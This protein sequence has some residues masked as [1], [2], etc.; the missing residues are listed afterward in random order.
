MKNFYLNVLKAGRIFLLFMVL[1]GSI[2]SEAYGIQQNKK[3]S[4]NNE[5]IS[6][7]YL[8][9]P[10]SDHVLS[11]PARAPSSQY[12]ELAIRSNGEF[13][14]GTLEGDPDNPN[15]NNKKLLYGHPNPWSSATTIRID[16]SDYWNYKGGTIGTITTAPYDSGNSN[17][18]VWDINGIRVTQT[19]TIFTGSTT[20]R[21]DNVEIK[22]TI[23]N[24]TSSSHNIGVR[25]MLDT[26]LGSNDGAPFRI[27]GVGDVTTEMEFAS[28]NMPQYWQ[29]FDSLSNPTVQSQGTLVGGNATVPDRFVA[30]YWRAINDTPWD[31]SI[32]PSRQITGDSAVGTYWNPVVL[33][34]GAS[35]TFI[36]YYGL[37]GITGGGNATFTVG[38]SSYTALTRDEDDNLT[39]NPFTVTAYVENITSFTASSVTATISLPTGLELNA[40]EEASKN[41]GNINANSQKQISWQ[42]Q[43]T[44][45]V[46][47]NLTYS[48]T[49]NDVDPADPITVDR[50]IEIP[51]PT[52]PNSPTATITSP[53]DGDE[54]I[55]GTLIAF[56][57]TGNDPED[58]NLTGSSLVW[59]SNI[60]GQIGTGGTISNYD[61]SRLSVGLHIITLTATD[62]GGKT[63]SASIQ[64]RI[65]A[66]NLN[67][68]TATINSP[69]NGSVYVIG[70][71]IS[72]SGSATDPEDGALGGGSL[73]WTSNKDGQIGTDTSFNTTT[74]SVG[75]HIITLTATDSGGLQGMDQISLIISFIGNINVKDGDGN[76]LQEAEVKII[77]GDNE[78]S[79]G[80]TDEDGN[81]SNIE[82]RI[83]DKVF[84]TKKVHEEDQTKGN[85]PDEKKYVVRLDNA[86]IFEDTDNDNLFD[87]NNTQGYIISNAGNQNL[88]LQHTKI[89]YNLVV[90]IEWD[91]DSSYLE[92]VKTG[93]EKA[94]ERLYDATDG[95]VYF[96]KVVVYDNKEEWGNA[97]IQVFAD[98]EKWYSANVNGINRGNGHI[99]FERN[100]PSSIW[101][102]GLPRWIT[103]TGKGGFATI[104][105]EFGHYGFGLGDQYCYYRDN[106]QIAIEDYIPTLMQRENVETEFAN[107]QTHL[108]NVTDINGNPAQTDQEERNHESDWKTIEDLHQRD[109][110]NVYVPIIKPYPTDSAVDE[111]DNGS[112]PDRKSIWNG[113]LGSFFGGSDPIPLCSVLF[114]ADAEIKNTIDFNLITSQADA[115]VTLFKSDP[116][117]DWIPGDWLNPKIYQGKTNLSR[118]IEVLGAR[119]DND[120]VVIQK[121]N[122]KTEFRPLSQSSSQ[123]APALLA[124]RAPFPLSESENEVFIP[125]SSAEGLPEFIVEAGVTG[126]ALLVTIR[127][128]KGLSSPPQAVHINEAGTLTNLSL[129]E[130]NNNTFTGSITLPE[131]LDAK[132]SLFI[133]G[134]DTEDNEVLWLSEIDVCQ[135][136]P[137]NRTIWSNGE[138][139]IMTPPGEV[140]DTTSL[141]ITKTPVPES[142]Q[143]PY[144]AIA[145]S[146][147]NFSLPDQGS[148]NGALTFRYSEE[149]LA[150]AT[151]NDLKVYYWDSNTEKWIEVGGVVDTERNTVS[152]PISHFA[153]YGLFVT[154][155]TSPKSS[156]ATPDSAIFDVLPITIEG[157][158]S[159]SGGSGVASVE[160]SLDGGNTW[161]PTSPSPSGW[162]YSFTPSL[163]GTYHLRSRAKDNVGN[164]EASTPEITI[165]YSVGSISVSPT[166][167]N[168]GNVTVGSSSAPQTFT[169]SNIGTADLVLGT[170]TH[171]GTN[172]SEFSIPNDQ[173][174]GQTIPPAEN[175]TVQVVF[176]PTSAGSKIAN[177]S[178]P[179]NA[180]TSALEVTLLGIGI[181]EPPT[182]NAGLDRTVSVNSPITLDGSNSSD[183]DG[184]PLT[185]QWTQT[186]G[187]TVSLSSS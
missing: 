159:D 181:G 155:T 10:I 186:A 32:D 47:G 96:N 135:I 144:L 157:T 1:I 140:E 36:T 60:D 164:Q 162:T 8:R 64:I 112:V 46:H 33:Q 114:D 150:G 68:P 111:V 27:P 17:I 134:N 173:C 125:L 85:H 59:T 14:M 5:N 92:D 105:H 72:F 172:A 28:S 178:I 171:T 93:F 63:G 126:Q 51:P 50:S 148:I 165:S 26:M 169:I 80:Q 11:A 67:A 95:Q 84:A 35:K 146:G 91:V 97:D 161:E 152:A 118:A 23:V 74:L 65:N 58:G 116:W 147:Y 127:S 81:L 88:V 156:F 119:V 129:S 55:R 41:L 183:P 25:V 103:G 158:A 184:D 104:V 24:N 40:G 9:V 109:Y 122:F 138:V 73:V 90:S 108:I 131:S 62:S 37:S 160:I 182:A 117:V 2:A 94:S 52:N 21:L 38:L 15:D 132:G 66:Q 86:Y 179:S 185:Y 34:P 130:V 102:E 56:Q 12:V 113:P 163:Q 143:Q 139:E 133:K 16:G 151:E 61:S 31:F 3:E 106:Q 20:G 18:T 57:G 136:S 76:N 48:V 45:Q 6:V 43:A 174:S 19:L 30:A 142:S 128:S 187:P 120:W 29:A 78:I 42:V 145:S 177:L 180:D 71:N 137:Y 115:E 49:V 176:S 154:D 54:F 123:S 70:T 77:R 168:F 101:K 149:L 89:G 87:V 82:M 98:N 22:Y 99:Y 107:P 170:I 13:T 75:E 167:R 166:S 7:T 69:S 39:P 53:N 175:C 141:I 83:G 110:N 44:G 124:Q 121:D 100:V 79:L 153:I 4:N